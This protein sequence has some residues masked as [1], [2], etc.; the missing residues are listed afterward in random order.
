MRTTLLF[1]ISVFF[2]ISACS[3]NSQNTKI[4]DKQKDGEEKISYNLTPTFITE[5]HEMRGIEGRIGFLNLK[6][7]AKE[8]QKVLWHFWGE[9]NEISGTFKLEGTH[10]LSGKKTPLLVNLNTHEKIYES[11]QPYTQANLG[12]IKSMPSTL[13]FEEPGVWQLNVFIDNKHF[14]ELVV[15]VD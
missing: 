3:P 4:E 15:E 2:V 12:A 13:L 14:A 9:E 10:L 7:K 11:I 8:S 1:L 5:G 6:F